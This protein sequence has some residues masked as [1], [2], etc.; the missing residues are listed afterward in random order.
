MRFIEFMFYAL[1]VMVTVAGATFG[2]DREMARR[3][4]ERYSTTQEELIV[5]CIFKTNCKY[6]NDMLEKEDD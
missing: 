2:F 6:Y 4:Y 3:D 5:G 1:A